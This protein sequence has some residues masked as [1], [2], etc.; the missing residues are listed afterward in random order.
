MAINLNLI[1]KIQEI[2]NTGLEIMNGREKGDV[3][4][5]IDDVVVVNNYEFGKGE[6]GDY[7]VFTVID[8]DTEFFFGSSVVTE[9]FLALDNMLSDEEKQELLK[10]G[11]EMSIHQKKSKNNRKYLYNIFFPNN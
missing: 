9:N 5:L 8:N 11:L 3:Q 1:K 10:T 2:S 4:D 7:V 6:Q